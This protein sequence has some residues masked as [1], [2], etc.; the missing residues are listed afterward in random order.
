MRAYNITSFYSSTPL[1]FSFYFG[2]IVHSFI[3][4]PRSHTVNS[5]YAGRGE[6]WWGIMYG[7]NNKV[8]RSS[9][10][11]HVLL[12]VAIVTVVLFF[13]VF[14]IAAPTVIDIAIAVF[15]G[16]INLISIHVILVVTFIIIHIPYSCRC[17]NK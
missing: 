10:L 8:I 12:F 1:L 14:V 7:V 15:G 6:F 2:V 4:I 16:T 3:P 9:L 11:L 5:P 17:N 13:F